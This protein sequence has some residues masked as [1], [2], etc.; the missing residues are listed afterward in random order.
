MARMLTEEEVG[1]M[2]KQR[3]LR[4]RAYKT[5][6]WNE[7]KR[8]DEAKEREMYD[9][10]YRASHGGLSR[11]EVA[12]AGPDGSGRQYAAIKRGFELQAQREFE[13]KKLGEELGTRRFEAEQ[14]R[15]GMR[16]QGRDAA[17]FNKEA[18][19]RAAELQ[20]ASAEK[21]AGINTASA[22]KIAGINTAS[23]EKI[24]KEKMDTEYDR[25]K[26]MTEGQVQAEEV[27]AN[28]AAAQE[29]A[30]NLMR[31][32][33]LDEKTALAFS[34]RAIQ[35]AR[36]MVNQSKRRGRPTMTFEQA[37]E[38]VHQQNTE[39]GRLPGKASKWEVE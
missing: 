39:Y 35:Q 26:L 36:Q 24:N 8:F 2:E 12:A 22:E 4:E 10:R 7:R 3:E 14:K 38:K 37:I 20:T 33:Q 34:Q 18:A 16:E 21:I 29:Y 30:Q 32:R 17:E 23:A 1:R 5:M 15:F 9:E 19:I 11:A 6:S 27:K 31:T 25:T 28:A 13:Q